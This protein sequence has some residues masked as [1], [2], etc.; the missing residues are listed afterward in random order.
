VY[1]TDTFS[2]FAENQASS[3]IG[4]ID[5]FTKTMLHMDGSDGS[6]TFTDSELTPKT[7]T[8]SGG[9]KISTAQSKFGGASG[10][11]TAATSDFIDTPANGDFAFPGDFTVDLWYR[12]V[13]LP[14][15]SYIIGTADDNAGSVG[16]ELV[17]T[18][19]NIIFQYQFT[20]S[21]AATINVAHGFSLNTWYHIAAVRSGTSVVLYK[22]GNSIGTAT[23]GTAITNTNKLR[24]GANPVDGTELMD[25]YLDEVRVSKGIA[26]WTSNFTPNSGPYTT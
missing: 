26:R 13:S 9:A 21:W 25:G 14:A 6:T 15:G 2:F 4:G 10:L 3:A 20:G 5:S 17:V 18:G 24:I 16:W 7:F 11:F 12:P 22:D 19:T 8:A 1:F 23:N